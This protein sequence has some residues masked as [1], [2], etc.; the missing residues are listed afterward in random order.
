MLPISCISM[1]LGYRIQHLAHVQG[2]SLM[3]IASELRESPASVAEHLHEYQQIRGS[4]EYQRTI[5][6]IQQRLNEAG[7]E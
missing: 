6:A 2:L 5:S 7:A 3:E 4:A 1:R